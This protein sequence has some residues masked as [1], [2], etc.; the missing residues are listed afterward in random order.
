MARYDP[1]SDHEGKPEWTS[2]NAS[3]STMKAENQMLV[4]TVKKRANILC[5]R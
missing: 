1:D 5:G 4:W 3:F 2:N